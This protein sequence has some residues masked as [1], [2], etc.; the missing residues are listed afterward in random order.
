MRK[1]I[2]LRGMLVILSIAVATPLSA[3][4]SSTN[5]AEESIPLVRVIWQDREDKAVHWGQFEQNGSQ[6]TF[7]NQNTIPGFPELDTE[8]NELVQM[9]RLGRV[10]LVGVRDDDD[11]NYQ[12]GWVALDLGV[13]MHSHGDHQDC[14]Y[15]EPPF[16]LSSMID[17]AQGNPAHLY[18]YEGNFY[19]A[20]DKRN[21]FT[22][23]APLHLLR[24]DDQQHGTFYQGGAGHITLA[25]V[26]GKVAY[27]TWMSYDE[28]NAGR[29]DV[30][31][32]SKPGDASI[33]YS[34]RLPVSGLHGA[35]AN[36][37]KVFFA[38][39]DGVYYVDADVNL[40]QSGETVEL[41]HLS[42][43][44][45]AENN[46]P[47]RTGAFATHRNWVLCTTGKQDE[48]AL[49]LIDAAAEEPSVIKLEIDTPDGLTLTTPAMVVTAAGKRYAFLFQ[50]RKTGDKQEKLVVV[51]LD[52]NGDRDLSD[53]TVIKQ[54]EVGAS[55]VEGHYGHHEIDF[56]AD[57]NWGVVSNPGT[58]QL[59]LL[60]LSDLEFKGTYEVGGMPTKVL[61]IGGKETRH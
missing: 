1:H 46:R 20:N 33:A 24:K 60:S 22:Q 29:I 10:V 51:D 47:Y 27:S 34:F 57:G 15:H 52:P 12:S 18:T 50:D 37:G 58:G 4:E 16:V 19:L 26:E 53:A 21:G 25:A 44:Q 43:G 54:L 40:K 42:L 9:D 11:G 7:Q 23:F 5:T 35:T 56:D 45:D 13:R 36:S 14:I 3:A 17:Q 55:Q 8:R 2:Y 61:C 38:P 49:C 30:S 48:A 6:V 39:S 41:K 28:A 59:Q 31:D 32:L